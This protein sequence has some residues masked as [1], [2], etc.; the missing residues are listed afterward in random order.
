MKLPYNRSYT[1]NVWECY[2]SKAFCSPCLGH[3]F[4]QICI[5]HFR[6][7]GLSRRCCCTE[8]HLGRV[9]L[10]QVKFK[11]Q[12]GPRKAQK[13]HQRVLYHSNNA[14]ESAKCVDSYL[15]QSAILDTDD[16]H[17]SLLH[18][19]CHIIQKNTKEQCLFLAQKLRQ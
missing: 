17:R 5:K 9:R 15:G 8:L 7:H 12:L 11:T 13:E 4:Y 16:V 14:M 3:K 6:A 2:T 10:Q 19:C 1:G 18:V